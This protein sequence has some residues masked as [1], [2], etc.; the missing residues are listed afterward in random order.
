MKKVHL[1]QVNEYLESMNEEMSI[2]QIES[3]F[4]V[5]PTCFKALRALCSEVVLEVCPPFYD[6]DEREEIAEEYLNKHYHVLF[7]DGSYIVRTNLDTKPGKEMQ[8]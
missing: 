1:N 3:T 4:K 2:K 6:D 5:F 8:Q 7:S